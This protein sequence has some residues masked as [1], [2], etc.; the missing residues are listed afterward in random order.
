MYKL[1]SLLSHLS[2]LPP[3]GPLHFNFPLLWSSGLHPLRPFCCFCHS[4]AL[5]ALV[6]SPS[7]ETRRF[8]NMEDYVIKF[9]IDVDIVAFVVFLGAVRIYPPHLYG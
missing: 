5:H 6:I 2:L 9:F 8:N 3:P 4:P 1:L 7:N